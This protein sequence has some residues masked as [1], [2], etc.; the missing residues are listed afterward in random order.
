MSPVGVARVVVVDSA[1]T[2][3]LR[4]PMISVAHDDNTVVHA[5]TTTANRGKDFMEPL[6]RDENSFGGKPLH[7]DVVTFDRQSHIALV[8]S[9]GHLAAHARHEVCVF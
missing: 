4:S 9:G 1:G 5:S 7:N 3:V 6:Y 2:V 8:V